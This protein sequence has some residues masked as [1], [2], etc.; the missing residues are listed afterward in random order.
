MALAALLRRC[1]VREAKCPAASD[2]RDRQSDRIESSL[3]RLCD[4]E[5][6]RPDT[7]GTVLRLMQTAGRLR[8]DRWAR[9]VN[10]QRSPCRVYA[11][12]SRLSSVLAHRMTAHLNTMSVVNQAVQNAI[13]QRG[14]ADLLMPSSVRQLRSQYRRA[15][16]I[17]VLA[18][19]PEIASLSPTVAPLPSRRM[20]A[21]IVF[22]T[23][24]A[25]S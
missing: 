19:L 23:S 24:A 25:A 8:E 16:L 7:P 22:T 21:P 11:L 6:L 3:P 4:A 15:H 18:D 9:C 1:R 17:A 13:S 10:R 20:P 12:C 2:F 14:I 5:I